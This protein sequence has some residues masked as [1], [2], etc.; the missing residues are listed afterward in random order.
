M[1]IDAVTLRNVG[2]FRASQ[3]LD[4]AAIGP[5]IVA[6]A[7]PN[8]AGKSTILE[9]IP[10]AIYRTT[11]SRGPIAGLATARDA[12]VEVVGQNGSP[13]TV[14]LDLDA[15]SGKTEAM[16]LDL[17]GAPVAGPKVREFDAAIASRFPALSVYLA[18]AFSSQTGAGSILRMDR[19]ERRALFGRLLGQERT[20]ALAKAARDRAAQVE[21]AMVSNRAALEA[22]RQGSGDV[23]ALEA[24]LSSAKTEAAKATAAV[25]DAEDRLKEA[26]AE[27]GQRHAELAD[28]QRAD[29]AAAEAWRRA[30]GAAEDVARLDASMAHLA[31]ILEDGDRIRADAA[32]RAKLVAAVESSAAAAVEAARRK[33][34]AEVAVAAAKEKA[35]IAQAREDALYAR[36]DGLRSI[37]DSA[38]EIEAHAAEVVVLRAEVDRLLTAGHSAADEE[39]AAAKAAADRMAELRATEAEAAEAERKRV[40]ATED[41]KRETARLRAAQAAMLGAPCFGRLSDAERDA[42]PALKGHFAAAAEAVVA[43]A[44]IDAGIDALVNAVQFAADAACVAR[45]RYQEA[46]KAADTSCRETARLRTEYQ[47]AKAALEAALAVDRSAAL[48]KAQA[49]AAGLEEA[50]E[51]ATNARLAAVEVVDAAR[52]DLWHARSADDEASASERAA[53]AAILPPDRTAELAATERDA[54]TLRGRL[55]ASR[56]AAAEAHALAERLAA[57]VPSLDLAAIGE[58]EASAEVAERGWREARGRSDSAA[59]E[60]ARVG[61]RLEAAQEAAA[62][63]SALVA[64]VAPQE[65]DLADWRFLARGLGREGVQALEMDAAGPRVSALANELLRDAYGPRFQVRFETQAARADGKGVKETF[66]VVVVDTERGREGDGADLSGGEKVIVGEALGL[67]VALFHSQAGGVSI[68]TVVRDETVGA[69]DPENAERYVAMLK[70]FLHVGLVHQLLFVSHSERITEMADAVV[71]VENGVIHVR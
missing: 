10:G 3:T 56:P 7:G 63:V 13:F 20:E 33:D 52:D 61:V 42:C 15:H 48:E 16:L 14:R 18:G 71:N 8:G 65:R 1:R 4:L 22:V 17:E 32:E 35:R 51:G 29:R 19:A 2:P 27:V 45:G 59:L 6:V 5:G 26:T 38:T 11:P 23:V 39:R 53:R 49:E 62:Q 31:P 46:K 34:A 37:L 25:R 69:L 58:A 44:R 55:E 28:H 68:Q 21:A 41:G 54:A 40:E 70:S 50:R 12:M 66:D 60:A 36:V 67:G 9:A 47:E 30:E 24:A 57:V 43:L 64:Q